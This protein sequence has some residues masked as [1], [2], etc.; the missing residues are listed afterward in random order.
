MRIAICTDIFLPQLSGISDSI[1]I[2]AEELRK[3]GHLVRI[4]APQLPGAVN[5]AYTVRFASYLIPGSGGGLALVF[6]FGGLR[7]IRQ[8]KPDIIHTQTFSTVGAFAAW[9]ARR[10]QVPLVGTDHTLPAEY[11]HYLKLDIAPFRFLVRRAAAKYYSRCTF[12]A[13]PSEKLIEQLR[14]Y[15]MTRPAMVISN[16]IKSSLFRPLKDR[17]HLKRKLGI[18][19]EAV[20]LFGRVAKEKDLDLAL[21][22][23]ARVMASRDTELVVIGDG[24]YRQELE[25]ETRRRCI[26]ERCHFPGALRGEELV[27]AINACEVYLITSQSETQ[28][29]TMLQASAC[30]L[31]VVAVRSGGLPEYVQEE[32]TGY[33]VD[34]D[35]R[36]GLVDRIVKLLQDRQ[37][38]CQMGLKGREFVNRFSPEA[39][40]D[41]VLEVY[42]ATLEQKPSEGVGKRW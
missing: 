24:P 26:A 35:D 1:E 42:A 8:F 36:D 7:D 22:V 13:A 41:R 17:A 14:L 25:A 38:A 27:E 20:L 9:A 5:D 19:A 15:G 31:P 21:D 34:A 10:L 4:Y 40:T 32:V 29:M 3:R 18:G 28:S 37:L 6:P 33:V 2:I 30:S 39:T 23:S 11:L 16:P 12:V